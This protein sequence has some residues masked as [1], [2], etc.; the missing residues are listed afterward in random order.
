METTNTDT[1]QARYKEARQELKELSKAVKGLVKEGAFPTVNEAIIKTCYTDK[2]HIEF[3]KF[4]EWKKL[5]KSIL[6]G[7]KGFPIWTRPIERKD[8]D[9]IDDDEDSTYWGVCYLFSNAQVRER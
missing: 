2:D 5:G 8:H 6:K 4:E 3:K 9:D 1:R 7:S